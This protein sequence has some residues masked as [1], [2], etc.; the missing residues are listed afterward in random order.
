MASFFRKLT[1]SVTATVQSSVS[2]AIKTVG[3]VAAAISLDNLQ[4]KYGDPDGKKALY[5]G[6]DL[7]YVSPRLIGE[8]RGREQV[9]AEGRGGM[10]VGTAN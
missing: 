8:S 5:E 2:E 10:E 7:T 9:G 4:D 3:D 1:A 6:L